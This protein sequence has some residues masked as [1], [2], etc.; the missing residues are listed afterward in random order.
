MR[1]V[2]LLKYCDGVHFHRSSVQLGSKRH[3]PLC[4]YYCLYLSATCNS[5]KSLGRWLFRLA[6]RTQ[7][8]SSLVKVDFW[9]QLATKK[10]DTYR[11]N[12]DAQVRLSATRQLQ[13]STDAGRPT[14]TAVDCRI[15]AHGADRRL[16]VRMLV[17]CPFGTAVALLP[18]PTGERAHCHLGSS[19]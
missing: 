18:S 8:F 13:L 12:D 5:L 11:L 1:F 17:R 6:P 10:L 19:S 7:A 15:V 3:S 4:Y 2:P 16:G 9:T 14:A